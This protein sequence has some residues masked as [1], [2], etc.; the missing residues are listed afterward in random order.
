MDY[1]SYRNT[2]HD[3]YDPRDPRA[4]ESSY[5]HDTPHHVPLRGRSRS[6]SNAASDGVP[7]PGQQPLKSAI[8]N[9][10]D[11]SD[12][13]RTVH[14]DLI[15]QIAAE[16]KR[17]VLDEI[18]QSGLGATPAQP[19]APSQQHIPPSP[20]STTASF[21]TRNVYT[22]P[23]PFSQ[24]TPGQHAPPHDHPSREPTFDGSTD[25]PRTPRHSSSAPIDIPHRDRAPERPVRAVRMATDDFTPIEKMWQRL[26]DPEGRP[27]PRLGE[28]LRGLAMHLIEDYEPKKSLVISPSKMQKFYEDVKVPDEIY[29]WQTI[30]GELSYTA[31]GRAYQSMRCQHHLIQEHPAEAP[32]IP[33]LTPQGFQE[34]MTAMIQAYPDT[35]YERISRAALDMPISNADNIKER[36]PKT[37]PRRMFPRSENVQAQQRCAASLSAEGAGPLRK[38]PSFPPPPPKV[39]TSSAG[40]SLERERSPYGRQPEV[41]SCDSDSERDTGFVPIERQRNPYSATPSGGKMYDDLS[42]STYSDTTPAP[43]QRRRAGSTASQSQWVPPPSDNYDQQGPRLSTRRTRSPNFSSYGTYSD[44]NINDT[45]ASYYS[46]NLHNVQDDGR[47]RSKDEELWRSRHRRSTVGTD[48]S[49]HDPPSRSSHD[50]YRARNGASGYDDRGYE[51]RRH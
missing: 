22:P 2:S 24:D 44:G 11:Q 50:D 40:P 28:F 49:S 42:Q 39:D 31:L 35:E 38:A 6:S 10:F 17:S 32:C 12:A 30:F 13:A 27:L 20:D 16:V 21:P 41:K 5:R 14:P 26:F 45:P 43:S 7:Q 36:F 48:S 8:G 29:P 37:L 15:A 1:D 4:Y 47:R 23:S 34:W 3:N 33:A 46:S 25:D 18:K 9:A 51:P 19:A